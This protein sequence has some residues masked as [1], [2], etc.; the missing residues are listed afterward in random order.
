LYSP[1]SK[2]AVSPIFSVTLIK[3]INIF[4]KKRKTLLTSK[5]TGV[6]LVEMTWETVQEHLRCIFC[7]VYSGW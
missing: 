1:K 5:L 6:Y 3:N 7:G 4:K 2:A